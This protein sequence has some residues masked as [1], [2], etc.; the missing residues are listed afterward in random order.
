MENTKENKTDHETDNLSDAERFVKELFEMP[1]DNSKVG[2]VQVIIPF[3]PISEKQKIIATW[4]DLIDQLSIYLE[5]VRKRGGTMGH[6]VGS[7]RDQQ[8]HIKELFE[9]L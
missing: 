3:R 4:E 8:K 7:I 1:Y 9:N 6:K 5:E 2:Q